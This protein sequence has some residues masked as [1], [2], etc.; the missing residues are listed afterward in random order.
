MGSGG[1]PVS[2]RARRYDGRRTP[3]SSDGP[4]MPAPASSSTD[5][6]AGRAGLIPGV[7]RRALS[8]GPR[9]AG[10]MAN[11]AATAASTIPFRQRSSRDW[12][13][14]T[15]P[16]AVPVAIS[17][18][19]RPHL[20]AGSAIRLRNPGGGQHQLKGRG[21]AAVER[22]HQLLGEHGHEVFCQLPPDLGCAIAGTGIQDARDGIPGAGAM[23]RPEDQVA[24]FRCRDG[25]R[26]GLPVAHLP[27]QHHIRIA[28]QGAPQRFRKTRE[29]PAL[30]HLPHKSRRRL[31]CRN[32]MGSSKVRMTPALRRLMWSIAAASAWTF[33]SR[34]I[35]SQAPVPWVRTARS[36]GRPA[37][38]TGC[39]GP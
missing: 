19:S 36:P 7:G 30:L 32:S 26:D 6:K 4:A 25:R 8:S 27:N 13:M 20:P 29:V 39:R 37:V 16:W 9:Q 22:G 14:E 38:L 21:A 12:S 31:R 1:E 18:E 23:H 17:L 35:R 3:G 11:R 24:G 28:S 2:P 15:I 10:F 34:W 5:A 33:P